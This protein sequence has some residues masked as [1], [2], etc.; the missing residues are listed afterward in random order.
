MVYIYIVPE[1]CCRQ[2]GSP[3]LLSE[4]KFDG[5]TFRATTRQLGGVSGEVEQQTCFFSRKA[6]NLYIFGLF[7]LKERCCFFWGPLWHLFF[8][9]FGTRSVFWCHRGAPWSPEDWEVKDE[10]HQLSTES[11]SLKLIYFYVG[12]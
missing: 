2:T 6:H 9:G 12:Q 8:S 11:I 10:S 5:R 7:L 4:E 3:L 1:K